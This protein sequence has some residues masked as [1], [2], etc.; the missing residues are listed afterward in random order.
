MVGI[1]RHRQTKGS[2]TDRFHLNHRA[3]PRLHTSA[4]LGL[5]LLQKQEMLPA[6]D[7][8]KGRL[9]RVT[10]ALELNQVVEYLRD[11]LLLDKC[12]D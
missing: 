12:V 5:H 8:N 3:T 7:K 11:H 10:S 2:A 4:G 9:L 1:V 6:R